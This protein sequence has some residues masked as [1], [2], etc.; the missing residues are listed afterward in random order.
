MAQ[1]IMQHFDPMT[2]AQATLHQATAMQRR[3][4]QRRVTFIECLPEYV[5]DYIAELQRG[6]AD[7]KVQI[8]GLLTTDLARMV[9]SGKLRDSASLDTDYVM[10]NESAS[11]SACGGTDNKMRTNASRPQTSL[12]FRNCN[13]TRPTRHCVVA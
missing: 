11:S 8:N 9:K 7:A 5:D 6:L 4:S 2:V 10:T 3:M 1:A 13:K 12:L